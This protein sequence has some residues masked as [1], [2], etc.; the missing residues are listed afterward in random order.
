[1]KSNH[2]REYV[3]EISSFYLKDK[4]KKEMNLEG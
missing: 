4:D 3:H 1:M 2:S